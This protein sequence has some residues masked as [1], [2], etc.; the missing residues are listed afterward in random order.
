MVSAM[1]AS[2]LLIVGERQALAWI[3]STERMAFPSYR[4]R[5]VASLA[6]GDE[7]LL[8]T[9]R[10]CFHNPGRD[11]GRVIG[12][13]LV[14]TTVEQLDPPI[15]VARRQFG[16]GCAIKLTSLAPSG[17]GVELPPLVDQLDT[18][19]NKSGWA[20]QMRRPLLTLTRID[21]T[22]LRRELETLAGPPRGALAGY[23]AAARPA[24]A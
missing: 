5:E 18:F 2:H 6:I 11:R 17:Q 13:A 22:L 7:L 14:R 24:R 1:S 10:G 3:L 4:A 19:P 8:Y 12:R 15:D 23:L 16:L 21:A 20:A 9:T